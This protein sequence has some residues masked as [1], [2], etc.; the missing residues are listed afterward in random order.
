MNIKNLFYGF[1]ITFLLVGCT[2]GSY[3]SKTSQIAETAYLASD[4][5]SALDL[6]EEII[7][8]YNNKGKK[9][10]G[11]IYCYA[12]KAALA[13]EQDE[14]AI[15]YFEEAQYTKYADAEMFA[16]MVKAYQNIDNLS[17][18][19]MA[20]ED[21]VKKFPDGKEIK[22]I[23]K[24]LFETYVE[25]ENWDLGMEL[26][27]KF[28]DETRMDKN[29]I[30]GNLIINQGLKNDDVCDELSSLLLKNNPD[31]IVALEWEAKKY[32]YKAEKKYQKEMDI[33]E[34]HKTRK[35]YAKLLK[36]L[37]VVNDNFTISL[38]YFKKL[39]KIN[40]DSSYAKFLGNIYA[41]FNDKEKA[42]YYRNMIK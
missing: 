10:D 25:S 28:D 6:W 3:T 37:D 33:Y 20:L 19:I 24:R 9:A 41:R 13:L 32:F 23:Q 36:A 30:E 22:L 39:Y 4:Y 17:K 7:L 14:K 18:E 15:S 12:G 34:K 29:I 42:A 1:I 2:A 40:P 38:K 8:T 26:H 21:Y 31:N 5:K 35:Q 27:N 11:K 16:A